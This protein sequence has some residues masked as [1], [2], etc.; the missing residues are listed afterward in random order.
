[1]MQEQKKPRL[2]IILPG[3]VSGPISLLYDDTEKKK[4]F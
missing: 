3:F 2:M 1:M 4:M